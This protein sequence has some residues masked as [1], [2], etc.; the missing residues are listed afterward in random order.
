MLV[1][2]V[3][4]SAGLLLGANSVQQAPAS[5]APASAGRA[6]ERR[7]VEI[8][9]YAG[10][11]RRDPLGA[12]DRGKLASLYLER[13][14]E[15]GSS[16]DLTQAE[17]YAKASLALRTA[18]NSQTFVVLASVLMAQ[19]RFVEAL[20]AAEQ[21]D[22]QSP[23]IAAHRALIAEVAMELGRYDRA[24]AIFDSLRRE[25]L[26][27]ASIL[28][29][30]R[31]DEL[32]GHPEWAEHALRRV[33]AGA[34]RSPNT[35]PATIA[36]LRL[37]LAGIALRAGRLATADSDLKAGLAV[38]PDDHRLLGAQAQLALKRG[39]FRMAIGSGE[40]SLAT[41]L[42]PTTLAV[43]SDAWA[44]LGDTVQAKMYEQTMR[45]VALS[46]PGPPHRAW[47]LFL[48][49]HGR[50]VPQVLRR[51]RADLR[52]RKDIYGYDVYAWAL[53]KSGRHREAWTA[54]QRALALGTRDPQLERHAAA[55]RRA[56]RTADPSL[57]SG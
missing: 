11:A 12:A 56:L 2:H 50:E 29:L 38:A 14:R 7:E 42:D 18:H 24:R 43:L 20:R 21:A 45:T 13:S 39:R 54:M 9:F 31:W 17:Q 48:L 47:S 57:L 6:F 25:P 1:A 36:W 40:Q 37:R 22:T 16:Q 34:Q 52:V 10:R 55:I 51:V 49:D 5:G 23:G 33:L 32:T 46:Q 30:A 15:T 3:L 28:R 44:A 26:D 41:T 19:H 27:A 8:A 4:L 35:Q 53:H